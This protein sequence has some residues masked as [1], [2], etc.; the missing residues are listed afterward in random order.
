M[1]E[2]NFIAG[3]NCLDFVSVVEAIIKRS[4]IIDFGIVQEVQG[5]GIVDVSVAVSDTEQNMFCMTCVLANIAS[6]SLTVAVKPNVGDRVLVVYPR[7]YDDDMFTVTDNEDDNKKIKLNPSAKGYSLCGG[8]AILLNQYKT[9]GHKNLIKIEDGKVDV[10]LAYSK[11]E[12][13]N[14]L[15]LT[16]DEEGAVEL[17]NDKTALSLSK[18]G[19]ISVGTD[20]YEIS[21]DSDG[22]LKYEN[23]K[24]NSTKVEFTSSGMTI[25]DK[26]G[27]KIVSS[28]TDI[29][30]NGKL[31][32]NK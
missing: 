28:A 27:C 23:K 13:K 15:I 21:I 4:C 17:S 31:K 32:V 19:A 12:D 11:D 26:N 18:D 5:E 2:P 8:I 6:S 29:Q 22:Y 7:I 1:E 10:K 16:T 25:Q 24:D 14:F 30:I 9:A 20:N 3:N